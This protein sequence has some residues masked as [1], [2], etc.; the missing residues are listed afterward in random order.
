MLQRNALPKS[1]RDGI[2]GQ[3]WKCWIWG[4]NHLFNKPHLRSW[5][6]GQVPS[7]APEASAD[8]TW[9]SFCRF[10]NCSEVKSSLVRWWGRRNLPN[11]FLI[12][13]WAL[14]EVRDPKIIHPRMLL[15][16]GK[17]LVWGVYHFKKSPIKCGKTWYLSVRKEKGGGRGRA[18]IA[19]QLRSSPVCMFQDLPSEQEEFFE[20]YAFH[21]V[22]KAII[23]HL[24]NHHR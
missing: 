21:D 22:G 7:D 24:P 16:T 3:V 17:P 14:F 15:S 19:E 23:N 11:T 13:T 6:W 1:V 2:L 5:I 10:S 9:I 8:A 18:H 4:R 20:D 12:G